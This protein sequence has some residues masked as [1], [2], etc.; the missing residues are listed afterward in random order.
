MPTVCICERRTPRRSWLRRPL[1]WLPRAARGPCAGPTG[2]V[3]VTLVLAWIVFPLV[4]A[5]VTLGCGL[6]LEALAGFRLRLPLLAPVGLATAVVAMCLRD[7]D[8]RH[9]RACGT[10][11]RGDRVAGLAARGA[12]LRTRFDPWAVG[13]GVATYAVYA[14]P[15]VASGEATFAGYVKLDDT[16]TYL[17]TLDYVLER[18]VQVTGL[19]PS[20]YETMLALC[21]RGRLS[22]RQ[23]PPA[24]PHATCRRRSRLDLAAVPRVPRSA[25]RTRPLRARRR[26]RTRALAA[27]A[28]RGD[29]ELLGAPLRVCAVGR[30]EGGLR[31]GHARA[32]RRDRVAR[33]EGQATRGARA[34][35]CCSRVPRRAQRGGSDLARP[36]PRRGHRR[37]MATPRPAHRSGSLRSRRWRWPCPRSSRHR[38]PRQRQCCRPRDGRHRQPARPAQPVA[39]GRHLAERRLPRR[40]RAEPRHDRPRRRRPRSLRPRSGPRVPPTRLAPARAPRDR[41]SRRLRLPGLLRALDRGQGARDRLARRPRC[42]RSSAAPA[43]VESGR[44]VEGVLVLAALVGGVAW[45]NALASSDARLAPRGQLAELESIGERFAGDGP[46]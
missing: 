45:S 7:D 28:R 36:A 46:P 42:S 16:A 37:S 27:G 5:A 23:S 12:G 2:H 6:A 13:A 21:A 14:A 9:R 8:R 3:T 32:A 22:R 20:T 26:S 11:R 38:V 18:G 29:G 40:A 39:A 41:R 35:R 17:G 24:R 1:Q 15:T 43:L 4:L 10:A 25:P 44:R 33:V 30:R 31:G 19:A 34:G